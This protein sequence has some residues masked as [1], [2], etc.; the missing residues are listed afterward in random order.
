MLLIHVSFTGSAAIRRMRHDGEQFYSQRK[1]R[2]NGLSP[3]LV[4]L[5]E[6]DRGWWRNGQG[7]WIKT[8]TIFKH[9]LQN[10]TGTCKFNGAS[11]FE[12]LKLCSAVSLPVT[13]SLILLLTNLSSSHLCRSD[14]VRYNKKRPW[15][16]RNKVRQCLYSM[17]TPLSYPSDEQR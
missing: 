3:P 6:H 7:F 9:C 12:K 2:L 16:F 14:L 11:L 15:K 5:Q 1:G 13:L 17:F 10:E 4:F 8:A